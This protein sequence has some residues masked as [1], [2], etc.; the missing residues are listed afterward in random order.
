[1][2][3]ARVDVLAERKLA[4]RYEIR[5]VPTLVYFVDAKRAGRSEGAIA[6]RRL[7]ERADALIEEH[8]ARKD[9]SREAEP[10]GT[11]PA[12]TA[13]AEPGTRA[14]SPPDG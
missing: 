11:L 8:A 1:V 10:D 6:Y 5:A 14:T 9:T 2:L 3:V 7:R 12:E 4:A 13:P